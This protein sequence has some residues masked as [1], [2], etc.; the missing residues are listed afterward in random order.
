MSHWYARDGAP[1][2]TVIGTNG[3]E[4]ATTLRDAKKLDLVPSVTTV[5]SVAAK[6]GLIN[7]MQEQMLLAALTLPRKEGEPEADWLARVKEDGKAQAKAAADRGTDMHNQIEDVFNGKQSAMFAHKV[8]DAVNAEFGQPQ[9]ITEQSFA[10][11]LGFGG[12]VDLWSPAGIVIDFKTKDKVDDKTD[13]YDEHAMQ[14]AAYRIGLNVPS[15]ICANVFVDMDGNVKIIRH[16]EAEIKKASD[17]FMALLSFYR[18][19]NN[20]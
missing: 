19:K 3:K 18:I 13:V 16:E 20:I 15:A 7:W 5:L 4:R 8:Y 2:Y 10:C 11:Q 6:P 1:R 17:M 12:K 14:L 9:W